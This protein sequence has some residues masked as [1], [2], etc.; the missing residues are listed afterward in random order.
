MPDYG[1]IMDGDWA[2]RVGC[3]SGLSPEEKSEFVRTHRRRWLA[4]NRHRLSEEQ[5]RELEETIAFIGPELYRLPQDPAVLARAKEMEVRAFALLSHA[6]L[7][8]MSLH[9]DRVPEMPE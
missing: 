6:D 1:V 8:Q 5:V 9:G 4:A 3:M 7:Y 2:H